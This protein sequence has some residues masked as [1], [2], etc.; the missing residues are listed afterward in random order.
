MYYVD[1]QTTWNIRLTYSVI[2]RLLGITVFTFICITEHS[3]SLQSFTIHSNM[4]LKIC[5]FQFQPN[6]KTKGNPSERPQTHS[7]VGKPPNRQ[8]DS[9]CISNVQSS[10]IYTCE[11]P[12]A[13]CDETPRK[14][15]K[16]GLLN[17]T[18]ILQRSLLTQCNF[19]QFNP[20]PSSMSICRVIW[21][22]QQVNQ[23]KLKLPFLTVSWASN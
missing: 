11:T 7:R 23:T 6:R 5:P 2:F 14:W 16:F 19:S 17:C 18:L 10:T 4:Q 12:Q 21:W 8:I 20:M 22:L 15:L 9:R 13:W 1:R 3:A